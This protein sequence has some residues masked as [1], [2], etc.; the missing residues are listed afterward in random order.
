[1][2]KPEKPAIAGNINKLSLK[3]VPPDS[4]HR[5]LVIN[6]GRAMF[7]TINPTTGGIDLNDCVDAH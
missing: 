7:C 1:M 3:N 4:I 5:A 2:K 6:G